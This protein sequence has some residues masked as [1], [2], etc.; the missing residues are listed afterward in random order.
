[1]DYEETFAYSVL[2]VYRPN[3]CWADQIFSSSQSPMVTPPE[4]QESH[5][6]PEPSDPPLSLRLAS[7]P[8]FSPPV[9][10]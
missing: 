9:V 5:Q 3:L 1:M 6:P 2:T 4:L 10:K 7:S 8:W